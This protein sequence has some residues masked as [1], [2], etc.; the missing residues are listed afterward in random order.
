MLEDEG[1]RKAAIQIALSQ[2]LSVH[3]MRAFIQTLKSAPEAI[4]KAVLNERVDLEDVKKLVDRGATRVPGEHAGALLEELETLK[5]QKDLMKREAESIVDETLKEVERSVK[6]GKERQIVIDQ[7]REELER[8]E[9]IYRKSVEP[10]FELIHGWHIDYDRMTTERWKKAYINRVGLID[11]ML[12]EFL[13]RKG[14]E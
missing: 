11:R 9:R 6:S 7:R 5:E 14:E 2:N 10:V 12:H 13:R 8:D 4:K 3:Q 1:D